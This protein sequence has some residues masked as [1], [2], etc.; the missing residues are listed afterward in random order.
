M[1]IQRN[2]AQIRKYIEPTQYFQLQ[3]EQLSK[4]YIYK[5]GRGNCYP[6]DILKRIWELEV[7][8]KQGFVYLGE[9]NWL[10]DCLKE[11]GFENLNDEK[12]QQDCLA[13]KYEYPNFKYPTYDRWII[14]YLSKYLNINFVKTEHNNIIDYDTTYRNVVSY[15]G[16][17]IPELFLNFS[18][19]YNPSYEFNYE[20]LDLYLLG[21]EQGVFSNSV[22]KLF[23]VLHNL[24]YYIA[25]LPEHSEEPFEINSLVFDNLISS[26][27]FM[28]N[29]LSVYGADMD[30]FFIG[31]KFR[32]W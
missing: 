14:D 15:V 12:I 3:K 21:D 24:E 11:R 28:I 2:S 31:N 9:K 17:F 27:E 30:Y 6:E 32:Y 5:I 8:E 16:T 23:E 25:M 4:T 19:L 10:Q 20:K 1:H 18:Q 7:L 13:I 29:T 22:C 26:E